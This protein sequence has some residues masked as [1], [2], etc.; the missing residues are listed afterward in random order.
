MG[1]NTWQPV[2]VA[3]PQTGGEPVQLLGREV[4][5]PAGFVVNLSRA[6]TGTASIIFLF[7]R[8]A[9]AKAFSRKPVVPPQEGR[10]LEAVGLLDGAA[11][12]F[13]HTEPVWAIAYGAPG[14]VSLSAVE[15]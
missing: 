9:T 13:S 15:S 6:L 3:V 12:N 14:V 7:R 1:L 10:I 5:R 2:T 4:K 11:Y 8:E